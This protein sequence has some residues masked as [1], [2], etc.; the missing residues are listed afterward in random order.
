MMRLD[1][2]LATLD[3]GQLPSGSAVITVDD[4]FESFWADA[5]PLL[6]RFGYPVTT[7]VTTNDRIKSCSGVSPGCSLHAL[8]NVGCGSGRLVRWRRAQWRLPTRGGC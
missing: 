6:S 7:Y 4:T 1:E 8:E 5:W 3:E 2:A